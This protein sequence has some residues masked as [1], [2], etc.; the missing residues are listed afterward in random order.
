M[1]LPTSQYSPGLRS[2]H[3]I[4][5]ISSDHLTDLLVRYFRSGTGSS[6]RVQ[7]VGKKLWPL[8]DPGH[9]RRT[10]PTA[11]TGFYNLALLYFQTHLR[12]TYM[13]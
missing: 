11:V 13:Y 7:F 8:W 4:A 5:P 10:K 12:C 3:T 1:I 9:P 6:T 2:L